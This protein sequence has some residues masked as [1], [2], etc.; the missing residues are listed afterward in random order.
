MQRTKESGEGDKKGE[1]NGETGSQP[2]NAGS[3]GDVRARV[4]LPRHY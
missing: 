3:N 4:H 1:A 2:L